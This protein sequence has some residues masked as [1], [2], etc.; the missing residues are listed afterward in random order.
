MTPLA[1]STRYHGDTID[2][3][4]IGRY[5]DQD[6]PLP[7]LS[8]AEQEYAARLMIRDGASTATAAARLGVSDRTVTRWRH[9]W[10]A[11]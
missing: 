7:E 10:A 5:L 1:T 9:A 3:I 4:A 8:G 6:Q 2:L 11:A